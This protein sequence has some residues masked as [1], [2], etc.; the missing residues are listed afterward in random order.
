MVVNEIK[1]LWVVL[2]N[3]FKWLSHLGHI[4]S[5]ISKGIGTITK[6]RKV[7]Y[8]TTLTLL[9]NTLMLSYIMHYA[10]W[11][12]QMETFSTLLAICA[13]NSPVPSEFPAQRPVTPIFDVFFDLRLNKRSSKQSWGWWF[14]TLS[15]PLWCHCNGICVGNCLDGTHLRNLR[16]INQTWSSDPLLD[17]IHSYVLYHNLDEICWPEPI[18]SLRLGHVTCQGSMPPTWV[19]R[20]S[21]LGKYLS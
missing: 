4:S 1:L 3:I 11:R 14:E 17:R 19:G 2:D 16:Q 21:V 20:V 6:V 15:R 7:F 12:H 9:Y 5:K 8:K 18:R 13:G 10:W